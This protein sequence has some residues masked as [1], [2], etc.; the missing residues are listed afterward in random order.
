NVMPVDL[1]A[2]PGSDKWPPDLRNRYATEWFITALEQG[3]PYGAEHWPSPPTPPPPPPPHL[4]VVPAST[5]PL[6][7]REPPPDR[8]D[9]EREQAFRAAIKAWAYNRRLYPGWLIAPE[10]VRETLRRRLGD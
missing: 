4:G 9:A 7:H 8:P 2:L 1:S 6:P 3:K 5:Q 10:R